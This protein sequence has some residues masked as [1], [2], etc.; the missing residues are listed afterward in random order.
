MP[1]DMEGSKKSMYLS[2][3]ARQ[4]FEHGPQFGIMCNIVRRIGRQLEALEAGCYWMLDNGAFTG[5]WT[6][7]TWLR[8]LWALRR[9]RRTCLAVMVPDVLADWRATLR[10]FWLLVWIPRLL[11]YPVALVTQDGLTSDRVPWWLIDCLFVG[12]SDQHKRGPEAY[13]LAIAGRQRGKWIHVGRVNSGAAM[14]KYFSWA[15]SYDGTT[16]SRHPHQQVKSIESGL[17]AIQAGIG[18]GRLL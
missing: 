18:Q 17:S 3:S 16:F 7:R 8:E 4:F 15:N 6:L 9:Y 14:I 1:N 13:Q 12:G 5:K 11:G 2:S 10:R